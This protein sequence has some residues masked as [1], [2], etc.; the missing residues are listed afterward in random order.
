MSKADV[1]KTVVLIRGK[2]ANQ[3]GP[4]ILAINGLFAINGV[5][6]KRT[7]IEPTMKADDSLMGTFG[8]LLRFLN[9]VMIDDGILLLHGCKAGGG[10]D[11]T[12]LLMQLSNALRPR[13]VVGFKTVGYQSVEKQKRGGDT[14]REPGA[15]DTPHDTESQR[16]EWEHERY[17]K[18]G[19]WDDLKVLPW[20]SETSTNA[21]IAQNG[22]I[23]HGK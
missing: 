10:D 9:N 4:A 3:L 16:P 11:G 8:N 18:D 2:E 21:R 22:V 12:K 1:D 7:P 5:D 20:E 23:I 13:K 14:C 15:R 17:F 19:Q 6:E